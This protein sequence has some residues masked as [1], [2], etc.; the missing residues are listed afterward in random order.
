MTDANELN[1]NDVVWLQGIQDGVT[2]YVNRATSY[3]DKLA[4]TLLVINTD[5]STYQQKLNSGEGIDIDSTDNTIGV[6]DNSLTIAKTNGLQSALD[7]KQNTI[8]DNSLTIAKTNG[9]QNALDSKQNTIADN[10][11]T[12]AKTNGLQNALDSK[13]NTIADGSLTIAK[14][15]GLQNAL[16]SKLDTIE[17]GSLTIAKTNGLQNALDS[18]QNTIADGSL[19]IAKTNGLQNA[20]ESKLDGNGKYIKNASI[21]ENTLTLDFSDDTPDVTFTSN[22]ETSSI[23][24]SGGT[25]NVTTDASGNNTNYNIEVDNIYYSKTEVDN[26]LSD[27]QNNFNNLQK[28]VTSFLVFIPINL[29]LLKTRSTEIYEYSDTNDILLDTTSDKILKF[30]MYGG[31][32]GSGKET[33]DSGFGGFTESIII[34]PY[35][36][37]TIY[38]TI[39]GTGERSG[40][41]VLLANGGGGK[42]DKSAFNGGGMSSVHAYND[43]DERIDILISGG[44]GGDGNGNKY[45]VRLGLSGGGLIAEYISTEIDGYIVAGNPGTQENGGK[46]GGHHDTDGQRGG[47]GIKYSGG[48]GY[49][50]NGS[51]PSSGSKRGGGGG[52]GGYYGGGG[53]RGG[54]SGSLYG[55]GGGGGGSGYAG[56]NMNP[57]YI[58]DDQWGNSSEYRDANWPGRLSSNGVY[59]MNTKVLRGSESITQHSGRIEVSYMTI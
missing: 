50:G 36:I 31:N 30:K 25:I 42:G 41:D 6:P 10:S 14:T 20:L 47:S 17:D 7:S 49:N 3:T 18:K 37:N 46:G 53:G 35:N 32:G 13:Q 23:T 2:E 8:A 44:G 38:L 51:D 15:N 55:S 29:D 21:T 33:R 1:S 5:L 59:Y 54:S 16:D 40:E 26:L 52:G 22:S 24:S 48:T 27:M 34:I 28:T 11:L 9:L 39:G 12:I 19:T 56:D 57:T 45:D 58:I 43:D 4:E